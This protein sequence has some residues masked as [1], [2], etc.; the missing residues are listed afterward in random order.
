[1]AQRIFLPIDDESEDLIMRLSDE[2]SR[3]LYSLLSKMSPVECVERGLT[4][5]QAFMIQTIVSVT[6]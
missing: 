1:M 5:D 3:A 6:C 2:E 4:Q